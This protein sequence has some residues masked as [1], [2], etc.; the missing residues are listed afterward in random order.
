MSQWPA[1]SVE[2]LSLTF[3]A[4][5]VDAAGYL[6]V[7]AFAANMTGNTVLLGLSVLSQE[8]DRLAPCS[9][10]LGGFLAGASLAALVLIRVS[11]AAD[12]TTDLRYGLVLELPLI[13]AF[14]GL[15][16]LDTATTVRCGRALLLSGAGALGVQSVA[17]WR[18]RISGVATTFITGTLTSAVLEALSG[19][20]RERESRSGGPSLLAAIFATY[21]AAAAS[22]AFL[23]QLAPA[24]ACLPAL[25]GFAA[26]GLLV[27]LR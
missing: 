9:L 27:W 3:A 18:L 2:L 14:T 13:L 20:R 21:V 7:H 1:R 5:A 12:E 19:P 8:R 16:L 11:G 26:A 23:F 17:V 24:A 6:R 25:T 10:A 4:G 15:W 22:A